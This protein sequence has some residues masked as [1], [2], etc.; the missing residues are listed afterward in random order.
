M[1][2]HSND[3]LHQHVGSLFICE[4]IWTF[5]PWHQTWL[6]DTTTECSMSPDLIT[7]H[8]EP[9][10]SLIRSHSPLTICPVYPVPLVQPIVVSPRRSGRMFRFLLSRSMLCTHRSVS[11]DDRDRIP[12]RV[13][14]V[15]STASSFSCLPVRM[16]Q[17]TAHIIAGA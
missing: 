7:S 1:T 17:R 16:T 8:R 5:R 13:L 4:F 3:N 9:Q 10:T 15:L 2:C 14:V 6:S 11:E 12:C